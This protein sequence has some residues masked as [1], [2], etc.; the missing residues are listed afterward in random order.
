MCPS[1][2]ASRRAFL[3]IGRTG[4]CCPT[5]PVQAAS[6]AAPRRNSPWV[7]PR[8][9]P[10]LR[11]SNCPSSCAL[12]SGLSR[13]T[14]TPSVTWAGRKPRHGHRPRQ[15][16][17]RHSTHGYSV[18]TPFTRLEG[19]R[20]ARHAHVRPTPTPQRTTLRRRSSPPVH[21]H[22]PRGLGGAGQEPGPARLHSTTLPR[23]RCPSEIEGESEAGEARVEGRSRW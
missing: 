11:H 18:G 2:L 6:S 5:R 21:C 19:P 9:A 1:D 4:G 13:P 10:P 3:R 15:P 14:V 17:T 8:G 20:P 22:V 7:P 23:G 12:S 16:C